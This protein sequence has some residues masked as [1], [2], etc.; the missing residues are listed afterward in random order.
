[1]AMIYLFVTDD[2]S[3]KYV[4]HYSDRSMPLFYKATAFWG[5]QD[6]SLLFWVWVMS[7][8]GAIAL[9][10]NREK[11]KDL[12]PYTTVTLMVVTAFFVMLMAFGGANPFETYLAGAPTD[13]QGPQPAPPEP[14]H[15]DAP[16]DA[17]PRLHRVD[18]PVLLRDRRA[19]AR[20]AGLRVDRRDAPVVPRRLGC[21]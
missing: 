21:A 15:G 3:V 9:Y 20:Q 8:W 18:D 2:Y 6:G 1:M 17:L 14:V 13:G 5:G 7:I 19:R 4:Q 11:H 10:Q 16:A 12:M